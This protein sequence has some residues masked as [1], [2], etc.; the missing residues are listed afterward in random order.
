MS[1]LPLPERMDLIL[2]KE[3]QLVTLNES[4]GSRPKLTGVSFLE[5][6]LHGVE[7]FD[8]TDRPRHRLEQTAQDTL[9][10][11]ATWSDLLDDQ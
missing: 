7:P 11:Q 10:A 1:K 6:M 9:R 5:P 8:V 3:L 4:L 2:D